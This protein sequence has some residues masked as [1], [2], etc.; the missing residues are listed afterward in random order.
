MK[1]KVRELLIETARSEKTITYAEV[2]KL[3][4]LSMVNPHHRTELA[5]TLDEINREERENGGPMLSVVV[6]QKDSK[7]PGRGFFVLARDLQRQA[8][9]IDDETFFVGELNRV[10]E[11]YKSKA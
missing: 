6:V 11:Y 4:N 1:E 5:D 8:P 10:Y 7:R 2:G 9:D 3:A